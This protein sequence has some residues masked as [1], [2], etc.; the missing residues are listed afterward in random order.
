MV[1]VVA[2]LAMINFASHLAWLCRSSPAESCAVGDAECQPESLHKSGDAMLQFQHKVNEE[3]SDGEVAARTGKGRAG[4]GRTEDVGDGDGGDLYLYYSYF[5]VKPQPKMRTYSSSNEPG[6]ASMVKKDLV[7]VNPKWVWELGGYVF[8]EI[9]YSNHDDKD[10][11]AYIGYPDC[12]APEGGF[13]GLVIMP[14]RSLKKIRHKFWVAMFASHG[15]VALAPDVG[16]AGYAIKDA[17]KLLE[18][19][20]EYPVNNGN[21]HLM[22]Y[23]AGAQGVLTNGLN[24][25]NTKKFQSFTVVSGINNKKLL[26]HYAEPNPI[27]LIQAQNDGMYGAAGQWDKVSGWAAEQA[28]L[29]GGKTKFLAYK[30]GGHQPVQQAS[31]F[32]EV[33]KFIQDPVSYTPPGDA[34]G[35]FSSG[36]FESSPVTEVHDKSCITNDDGIEPIITI[37]LWSGNTGQATCLG[38]CRQV[39]G[40]VAFDYYKKA[41]DGMNCA[42]WS[43]SCTTPTYVGG[44]HWS[45]KGYTGDFTASFCSAL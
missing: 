13:P 43:E 41:A 24:A 44:S 25:A 40:C 32:S 3:K 36:T 16:K 33:L 29:D 1:K 39:K 23:S 12:A 18:E 34:G 4:K 17:R 11:T 2:K 5:G 27:L 26:D 14:G 28:E 35:I 30:D 22:G 15:V 38:A 42:L 9:W 45:W 10:W 6:W 8:D 21:I 7:P 19:T 37:N 20:T 31:F